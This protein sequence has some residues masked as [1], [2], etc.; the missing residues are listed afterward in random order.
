VEG[1]F[2]KIGFAKLAGGWQPV[3]QLGPFDAPSGPV[4][5]E[6]LN[7][8]K[9]VQK[10][11]MPRLVYWYGTPRW[12]CVTRSFSFIPHSEI[13]SYNKGMK[14]GLNKIPHLQN[15]IDGKI[16]LSEQDEFLCC[17]L[18]EVKTELLLPM[19][20]RV[21][22]LKGP[23]PYEYLPHNSAAFATTLLQKDTA[24]KSEM[25]V[26]SSS[27][28]PTAMRCKTRTMGGYDVRGMDRA[29]FSGT[30]KNEHHQ[31]SKHQLVCQQQAADEAMEQISCLSTGLFVKNDGSR[32]QMSNTINKECSNSGNE[33]QVLLAFLQSQ[34]ACIK[35]S[36][37]AFFNW[38]VNSEDIVSLANL[39][40]AVSDHKYVRESLQV[41]DGQTG[42]KGFKRNTFR[43]A[44]EHQQARIRGRHRI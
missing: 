19:D 43:E 29:N 25:N 11:E 20:E 21:A 36:P 15:N 26:Y 22:W 41:G 37:I 27:L 24:V 31:C 42:L 14:M 35:G 1:S 33:I 10:E 32:D 40:E 7:I 44:I 16:Q 13:I 30:I 8:F 9:E 38:L 4:R 23:K 34:K 5:D 6:W 3:I 28:S 18:E 17:G 12:E 2:R 39:A